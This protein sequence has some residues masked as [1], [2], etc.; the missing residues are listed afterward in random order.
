MTTGD[1]WMSVGVLATPAGEN[2]ADAVNGDVTSG[3]TTPP[4]EHI[5]ALFVLIG[6][7]KATAAAFRGSAILSH[8]HQAVPKALSIY[9]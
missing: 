2:V 6:Q 3:I 9:A 4:H 7:R 5:P 1:Y 8:I